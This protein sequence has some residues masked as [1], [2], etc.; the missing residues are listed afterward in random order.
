MKN[1]RR[2]NY[3]YNKCVTNRFFTTYDN[4]SNTQNDDH[5]INISW[6]KSVKDRVMITKQELDISREV[7]KFIDK[8]PEYNIDKSINKDIE[9]I[10]NL[11]APLYMRQRVEK[12]LQ[13]LYIE[14]HNQFI[15]EKTG[16]RPKYSPIY[17][18]I[19]KCSLCL[20]GEL[21]IVSFDDTFIEKHIEYAKLLY[22]ISLSDN[23]INGELI[24]NNHNELMTFYEFLS[25]KNLHYIDERQLNKNFK[26]E[27]L[28]FW[29]SLRRD[30]KIIY[31]ILT[32]L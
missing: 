24:Q 2:I 20:E 12:E 17:K 25:E 9:L 10:F 4:P 7:M 26:L 6:K 18:N 11:Y 22:N 8:E 29:N 19:F 28:R 32:K 1:T 21:M 14:K 31:N 15:N 23:K 30:F 5:V 27:E 3:I 13:K 16:H